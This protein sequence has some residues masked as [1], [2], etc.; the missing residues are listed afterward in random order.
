MQNETLEKI[1][2]IDGKVQADILVEHLK[3]HDIPACSQTEAPGARGNN[4]P[5]GEGIYV[6]RSDARAARKLLEDF[7][8]TESSGEED[9]VSEYQPSHRLR[10]RLFAA[11]AL[12]I[13][14]A[15]FIYSIYGYVA[16][17]L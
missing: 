7:F 12:V 11:A 16:Q 5:P 13:L 10:R 4:A 17:L 9:S 14:A 8:R 1:L 15:F 6:S 2:I 3:E